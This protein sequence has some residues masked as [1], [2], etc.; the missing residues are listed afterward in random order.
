MKKSNAE[1]LLR[2]LFADPEQQHDKDA[3]TDDWQEMCHAN[4]H[5][6]PGYIE[7]EVHGR[8][9]AQSYPELHAQI[10]QCDSCRGAYQELKDLISLEDAA[11]FAEPVQEAVFDLSYLKSPAEIP[12]EAS[13]P[14]EHPPAEQAVQRGWHVSELGTYVLALSEELLESLLPSTPQPVFQK[15]T[16][17]TLFETASPALDG[18]LDVVVTAKEQRHDP[19]RCTVMVTAKSPGKSWP[20]LG[21]TQIE[22][23]VDAETKQTLSTDA[24][25]RAVFDNIDKSKLPQLIIQAHP[26]L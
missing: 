21:G 13:L 16:D 17:R 2:A 11:G 24:H 9:A 23:W 20:Q 26:S 15:R 10:A 1:Q 22:L 8:N 4:Q 6:L 7:A 5:D 12:P 14:Y 3:S 18:K 25:G 19:A